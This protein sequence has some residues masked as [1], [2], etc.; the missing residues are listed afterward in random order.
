M[1]PDLFKD[2]NPDSIHEEYWKE[3]LDV[4]LKGLWVYPEPK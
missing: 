4:D 2:L 1:H 3:F